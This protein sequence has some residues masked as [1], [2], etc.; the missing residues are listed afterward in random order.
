MGKRNES[1]VKTRVKRTL[2]AAECY[3]HWPVQTGYGAACLDCHGCYREQYF[4][5][6]TKAPGKHPTPRQELTINDIR[7]AGG[8]VFV[9]GESYD[10]K[11]ERFSGEDELDAWLILNAP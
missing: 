11:T 9:I 8:A 2:T 1:H 5:V 10:V 7:A 6:E 4:A 3:Q